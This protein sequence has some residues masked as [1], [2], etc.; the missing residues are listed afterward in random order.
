MT[1]G[2]ETGGVEEWGR[3]REAKGGK[4]RGWDKAKRGI[5]GGEER[6]RAM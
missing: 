5:P 4:E 3:A 6:G 1:G 2:A